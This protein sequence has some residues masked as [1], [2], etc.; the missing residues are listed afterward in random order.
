MIVIQDVRLAA[1][2]ERW[3]GWARGVDDFVVISVGTGVAMGIVADGM[4][5]A[6]GG[7][8]AGEFSQS[9]VRLRSV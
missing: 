5:I 9:A 3:R 8:A 2:G 4:L 6:G 1:I 7:Y